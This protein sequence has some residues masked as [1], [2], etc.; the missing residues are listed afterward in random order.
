M[1]ETIFILFSAI[2]IA[3]AVG[4]RSHIR[5]RMRLEALLAVL[6]VL[7][8]GAYILAKRMDGGLGAVTNLSD[9]FPWGL[10]IAADLCGIALAAGGFVLASVVHIGHIRRFEPLLRPTVLTAFIAYTLVAAILVI[11]LGRPYRFW[12]PLVMWQPHSVMFEI[13][14]C[15]TLYSIALTLELAPALCERIGWHRLASALHE[16]TLPVVIVGAILSTLH[17]SSF[18]SLFLIVPQK[19]HALWYTPVL[20]VLFFLS[21]VCAGMAVVIVESHLCAVFLERELP[22]PLLIALG[23][24]CGWV[25]WGYLALK[26]VDAWWRG[27]WH[28]LAAVPWLGALWLAEVIVCGAWPAWWLSRLKTDHP[29]RGVVTAATLVIGGVVLNRINVSWLA[30][31]PYTGWV[32]VPS[33]ME[34]VLT[35]ALLL[36]G[37]MTFVAVCRFA[38]IFPEPTPT[39]TPPR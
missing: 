16:M 4:R 12:H 2:I 28:H 24:L 37:V 32:Y 20:P 15:I 10:W 6:A 22:A 5:L 27:A 29:P 11:D 25:L 36:M 26:V 1:L 31:V 17:Q 8:A 19:L 30:L 13:T 33:W 39:R 38:P 21:A 18:G 9:R 35:L 7:L 14:M 3:W 23:R 34:V